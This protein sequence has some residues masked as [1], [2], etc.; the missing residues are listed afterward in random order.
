MSTTERT[1]SD[2]AATP[3]P[4]PASGPG[5][6]APNRVAVGDATAP[7]GRTTAGRAAVRRGLPAA[8]RGTESAAQGRRRRRAAT[9][10]MAAA[11]LAATVTATLSGCGIR[12]TAVPV[13]AGLPA[14]RTACPPTPGATSTP[15]ANSDGPAVL[16][17][18]APSDLMPGGATYFPGATPW[19]ALTSALPIMPSASASAAARGSATPHR[20]TSSAGARAASPPPVP[21]P[22]SATTTGAS[23]FSLGDCGAAPGTGS[24]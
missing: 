8:V 12:S 9:V 2:T 15:G 19:D 21:K 18:A 17:T 1:N 5:T 7:G 24:P 6:P 10:A 16:T 20:A 3:A 14:S 4:N 13:D 22:T 11:V 23:G